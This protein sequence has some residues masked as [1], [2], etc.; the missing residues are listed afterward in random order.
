MER[1]RLSQSERLKETDSRK[2]EEIS[3]EIAGKFKVYL[4]TKR[5][6][7]DSKSSEIE[8]TVDETRKD[9]H[10]MYFKE[11]MTHSEIAKSLG[12]KS[13]KSIQR[14][15]R[16]E[17]WTAKSGKVEGIEDD[18]HRLYFDEG[19]SQR[20]VAEELGLK[21]MKA[22][23]RIFNEQG[24]ETRPKR[25]LELEKQVR[26]LYFQKELTQSEVA[27]GLGKSERWVQD[28]F[29][30][31]DWEARS[32]RIEGIEDDIFQKYFEEEFT[33]EQVANE[34]NLS[35]DTVLRVFQEM[36]WESRAPRRG[37]TMRTFETEEERTE[38]KREHKRITYEK[39]K[40]LRENLFGSGCKICHADSEIRKLF[41][42]KRDGSKH[43]EIN[44][45]SL[46]DLQKIN[47]DEWQRLCT[48]CHRGSH[49]IMNELDIE[50]TEIQSFGLS[51]EDTVDPILKAEGKITLDRNRMN[52]ENEVISIEDMRRKL[53][54]TECSIC[55]KIKDEVSLIIH[56]KAGLPH[57]RHFLW[58]RENLNSINPDEWVAL[59]RK[60][61]RNVHW[62]MSE[63]GFDWDYI[64]H[65]IKKTK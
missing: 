21:S 63:L 55:T 52:F 23:R 30:R 56:N 11:G 37:I 61:H 44:L 31:N 32:K 42:H 41:V 40:D 38:A 5:A 19:F 58:S 57:H 15:F 14:V 51:L 4:K 33:Q 17:G 39:I 54:G 25:D 64:E 12:Y 2:L 16:E 49:W 13:T 3:K 26:E 43:P 60:C 46:R 27:D 22:I 62:S 28:V 35:K 34:L 24:W 20:E 10:R 53:F 8:K 36:E 29:R 1:R 59:C 18:I 47:T 6:L 50:G 7:E 45:W 48:A 65:R 9:I